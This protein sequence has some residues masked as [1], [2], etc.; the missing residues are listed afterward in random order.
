MWLHAIFLAAISTI[1]LSCETVS[2][3]PENSI[4]KELTDLQQT[5]AFDGFSIVA[6]N[7][8]G[9]YCVRRNTKGKAVSLT[10][11]GSNAD[12]TYAFHVWTH[13]LPHLK[14]DEAFVSF[15]LEGFNNEQDKSRFVK[16]ELEANKVKTKHGVCV[17]TKSIHQDLLAHK[18][19]SNPEPM[20][21]EAIS[22]ICRNPHN[23]SEA[24]YLTYSHRYYPGHRDSS[25]SDKAQVQFDN[26]DFNAGLQAKSDEMCP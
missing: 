8:Y 21:L 2:P 17:S 23:Q 16:K 14:N 1:L 10:K 13:Q 5:I 25:L 20:L 7:E 11:S 9:W 4:L 6:P 26:L 15:I 12:E 24:A 19:T 18:R 3:K 22:L